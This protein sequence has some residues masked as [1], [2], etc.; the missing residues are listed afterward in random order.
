[1][2]VTRVQSY[3]AH[4]QS[5][6]ATTVAAAFGTNVVAG[7]V[8]ALFL[9]WSGS[10]VTLTSVAKTAGT[11]TIGTITTATEFT[12]SE[13]GG[14][15]WFQVTGSGSLTLT[16]TISAAPG[17]G[18]N[19]MGWELSGADTT[20]PINAHA[21]QRF[22]VDSNA[23]DY[24]TSGPATTTVADCLILG[25]FTAIGQTLVAGTNFT[26][27]ESHSGTWGGMTEYFQ[28][29]GTGSISATFTR[30]A[31]SNDGSAMQVLAIA[32][33]SGPAPNTARIVIRQA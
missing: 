11:A 25:G 28:M 24:I 10:G 22:F 3:Y 8:V 12:A 7:N 13:N 31:G 20:A 4:D 19:M 21:G 30:T 33:P 6:S 27:V 29:T 17:S 14:Y 2:A 32:P 16:M 5:G 15:A 26:V 23:T 18:L 9:Q 1:M